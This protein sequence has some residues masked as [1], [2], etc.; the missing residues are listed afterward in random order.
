MEDKASVSPG[1]M[2]WGIPDQTITQT[3]FNEQSMFGQLA[4]AHP[5]AV[6]QRESRTP[7][8]AMLEKVI[9]IQKANGIDGG[10]WFG[11]LEIAVFG[12]VFKWL[13]QTIGSCVASGGMRG[14]A[15]R[16]LAEVF[17]LNDPE[18]LFGNSIV[19]IDNLAHFAPYNYRA[20]R[21]RAGIDGNS[22]GSYCS[23]HTRGMMED[24]MIP[25]STPGLVSDAF[26]EPQSSS[27]YRS[28][29]A[30]DTLLNRFATTGR[31]YKLL[32]S[33]KIDST[34]QGKDLMMAY[35]PAMVCSNWAFKPDYVHP[36]WK[37][38]DGSPVVIYKRDTS[39]SWAHNM[40]DWGFV[41]VGNRW[42][43]FILN[44]WGNA[45]R[46][47]TWLVIPIELYDEWQPRSERQAIGE[48]DMAPN[49]VPVAA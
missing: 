13:A 41:L 30:N 10:F 17:L 16:C 46:N 15:D 22:D 33:P 19:G 31:I 29:G 44:S 28:W 1:N 48:I 3:Y 37:L 24:G 26:P 5:E 47:G 21:K 18:T 49:P 12:S 36:T 25:C 11:A 39:T 8:R 2:G 32:E 27:T 40:T 23:V 14:T 45:H 4:Q 20:G 38:S 34:Q 42:Y 6:V 35:K 7:N 43:V 9:A